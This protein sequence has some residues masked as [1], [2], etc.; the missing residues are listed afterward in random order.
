M[1][2]V[3][4]IGLGAVSSVHVAGVEESRNGKLVAVC[5]TDETLRD[6]YPNIPFYT[7]V[8]TMLDKEE[9]DVVHVCLPHYLHYPVTKLCVEKGVHVLQEKPLSLDYKEGLCTAALTEKYASKIAVCFQNR[10]NATFQK[11]KETLEEGHYGRV[12][13][14]KGLVAWYRSDEYYLEKPWRG[15]WE[16]A[17]GGTIINQAIHTL[18]L[19][20]AIGGELVSCKASL[21]NIT[22]YDV[23]VEDT[24]VANFKFENRVTGFYM[25][26][27]AYVANSSVEIEVLTEKGTFIIKENQLFLIDL[28]GDIRTLAQD[29]QKAGTKSYYGPSHATLIQRFYDAIEQETDDYVTVRDAL[30]SMLMI[31]A[32]KKSS[33]EVRT[34]EM[35]EIKRDASKNRCTGVYSQEGI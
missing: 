32:M 31:D 26:T 4:I 5:D 22:D 8:E 12:L 18:D 1:L 30:P 7:D 17:G 29:E 27:N 25:S 15:K 13:A 6:R 16:T 19:M 11:L 34:I 33:N 21:S 10:Y 24:A 23:E 35:E 3:A 28:E 9:L 20:Q 2:K 14:V